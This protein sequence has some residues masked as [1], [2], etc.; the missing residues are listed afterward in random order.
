MKFSENWLREWVDP[1]IDTAALVEQLTIAGLEVGGIT[2][3]ALRLQGIVVGEVL[4][5]A[6]HPNA[7]K[8]RVCTVDTGQDEP[9]SI[10]CGAPNVHLGMRTPTALVGTEM[11]GGMK[12]KRAK[13]RGVESSGMLCSVME[14]GLADSADGLMELPADAPVGE[15]IRN[16]LG[17]EDVSIELDLTPNR[18]DCLGLAGI[19]REVGVINRCPVSI[20][21]MGPVPARIKDEFPVALEAPVDCPR[22]VGRVVRNINPMAPTP[23]WMQERL[24]RGG[25]RS[26]SATVDITNYVLLEL[27]QPMHAFDLDRLQG[28]ILVRRSLEGENISLLDGSEM[29]LDAQTLVIADQSAPQ[30]L[31]GIMGG[32]D[33]AVT[34][35]THHIFLESAYF[36][37]QTIAGRGRRYGIQTASSHRFERGVDFGLQRTAMERATALVLEVVG[38]EPGP[39]I[40]RVV[41]DE[42]P[43]RLPI[44]LRRSRIRRVL[45]MEPDA[46]DVGEIFKRLGMQVEEKG[47]G[48]LITPPGFRFDMAI[49]TDLIE[50]IARIVGYD[51]LPT[52]IP[53]AHL[54]I[55]QDEETRVGLPRMRQLLV[56]RGYQEAI[57]YSF[58]D[59][60]LQARF[61]PDE[62]PIGLSNPISADMTVMRTTL[63]PGLI[64]VLRHNQNRQQS[65]IRLFESGPRFIQ[66][67]KR[68]IQ[69]AA[70][71]GILAGPALPEQW[72]APAR[73]VDFFDAKA[74]VAALVELAGG[75]GGRYFYC[76]S[77]PGIA[78]GTDRA[79]RTG[80][81]S[82]RIYGGP[83]P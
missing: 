20:P 77:P 41:D 38:G 63:W 32:R 48:W 13:L 64:Q 1:P 60:G 83:A 37:P 69:E 4:S 22:Y 72:G 74:D 42:L 65:R 45:G 12:I 30:A 29:T 44:H 36:S 47:D 61:D 51:K 70:L 62:V 19:A 50:E 28:G 78:P 43:S 68:T 67:E 82:G 3:V 26:I 14:L 7:D 58:I 52:A 71:A 40:E 25:L 16:Y 55:R 33:S 35:D 9:L 6:S 49:E 11:P 56:D 57:T 76:C 24:R 34:V 10:V 17:L 66:R 31:A 46:A 59:P 8:L 39:V 18:G 75:G 21:P 54:D 79:H 5:V 27:G 15:E 2:P 81:A 80:G 73:E 53:Q 23:M